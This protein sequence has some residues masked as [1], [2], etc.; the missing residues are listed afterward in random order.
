MTDYVCKEGD[1]WQAHSYFCLTNPYPE[2]HDKSKCLENE[3]FDGDCCATDIGT[4]KCKDN[5]DLTW[6]KQCTPG[7]KDW[8]FSCLPPPPPTPSEE[9]EADTK[10]DAKA[11]AKADVKAD[12][13]AD[14]TVEAAKPDAPVEAVKKTPA[15]DASKCMSSINNLPDIDCCTLIGTASCKDGYIVTRTDTC[16][17]I[18]H[19]KFTCSHP[20]YV[21]PPRSSVTTVTV[22]IGLLVV[23]LCCICTIVVLFCIKM[24]I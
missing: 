22:I 1:G 9:V 10:A 23:L 5:Y 14:G 3:E 24:N 13:K 17:G 2:N 21:I 11:D 18:G 15:H 19:Y 4:A 12:T 20:D 16:P 7:S 6:L 8:R